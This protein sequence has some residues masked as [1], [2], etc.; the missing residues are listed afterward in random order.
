M[1][2]CDELLGLGEEVCDFASIIINSMPNSYHNLLTAVSGVA[3]SG[4][5]FL[6]AEDLMQILNDEDDYRV[7]KRDKKGKGQ[8]GESAFHS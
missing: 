7:S 1:Q 6:D 2:A 8:V 3:R 4:G 5:G